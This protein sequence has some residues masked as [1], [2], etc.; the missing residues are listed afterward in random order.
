VLEG[1]TG[2]RRIRIAASA[3][4]LAQWISQHPFKDDGNA[5]LWVGFTR[6]S[7]NKPLTH[8]SVF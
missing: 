2:M 4:V 1:K 7:K 6:K 8:R 3:P 5:F